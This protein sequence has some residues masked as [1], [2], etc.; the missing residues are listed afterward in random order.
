MT[1]AFERGIWG[2]AVAA[3]CLSLAVSVRAETVPPLKSKADG[4]MM[5]LLEGQ[6]A[7][8]PRAFDPVVTDGGFATAFDAETRAALL[9]GA[10][11][12]AMSG[13]DVEAAYKYARQGAD[14]PG[15]DGAVWSVRF[16][17]ALANEQP[18][19]AVKSFHVLA[20]RF[21]RALAEVD[22]A[23]VLAAYQSLAREPNPEAER[24]RFL[25][26]LRT[27]GWRPQD[28]VDAGEG[29]RLERVRL[30]LAAGREEEARAEAAELDDPFAHLALRVDDRFAPV[31]RATAGDL[32]SVAQSRLTGVT[33]LASTA[34]DRLSAALAMA[35]L[36]LM[37]GEPAKAL[38]VLDAALERR[39]KGG[40]G[41]YVDA[42]RTLNWA[43]DLRAQALFALGRWDEGLEAMA[44]AAGTPEDGTDNFSQTVNLAGALT[45][46]GR[47]Q[48][49]LAALGAVNDELLTDDGRAWVQAARACALAAD[50]QAPAA[51]EAATRADALGPK[52]FAARIHARLCV[53]DLDAAAR[54]Y[55]ERLGEPEHRLEALLALQDYRVDAKV[56]ASAPTGWGAARRRQLAALRAR[57]DVREAVARAG[58]RLQTVELV[59]VH[60]RL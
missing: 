24:L 31:R 26:A 50:R 44:E 53:D 40:D 29:L 38:S 14:E 48:E 21:P 51:A 56:E 34:A 8:A 54:L 55:V 60:G 35:E 17:L 13:G 12:C 33:V 5:A 47:P 15:A 52:N 20:S 16:T 27:A 59:D 57:S 37:L 3:C 42:E 2:A 49:A 32:R 7:S 1:R 46:M 30:L 4:A 23:L 22:D 6:C 28:P 58:G 25:D 39:R 9:G 11:M 43:R 19:D 41:A 36:H 10:A 18:Q 45:F